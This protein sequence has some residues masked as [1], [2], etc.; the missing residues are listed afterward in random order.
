MVGESR[1]LKS[2]TD[3]A[4][5]FFKKLAVALRKNIKNDD[6]TSF[7]NFLDAY[8]TKYV[9]GVSPQPID[10]S[11]VLDVYL[12]LINVSYYMKTLVIPQSLVK[13]VYST[14][15]SGYVLR[16][17]PDS[18]VF[19]NDGDDDYLKY[20]ILTSSNWTLRTTSQNAGA[21]NTYY[22]DVPVQCHHNVPFVRAASG[23]TNID[24]TQD[25]FT[26]KSEM[27]KTCEKCQHPKRHSGKPVI[28]NELITVMGCFPVVSKYVTYECFL[29]DNQKFET[30]K[31]VPNR[32]SSARSNAASSTV[33]Y[34]DRVLSW[35]C[36]NRSLL[37]SHGTSNALIGKSHN[38]NPFYRV[39]ASSLDV[40]VSLKMLGVIYD[41][42]Q[43]APDESANGYS[44]KKEDIFRKMN[45]VDESFLREMFPPTSNDSL[46]MV[47]F[48]SSTYD[49]G[50]NLKK[51]A[52]IAIVQKHDATRV[53]CN[54]RLHWLFPNAHAFYEKI[55]RRFF[56]DSGSALDIVSLIREAV[57]GH[58]VSVWVK[59]KWLYRHFCEVFHVYLHIVSLWCNDS[60]CGSDTPHD[61]AKR[62]LKHMDFEKAKEIHRICTTVATPNPDALFCDPSFKREMSKE[63]LFCDGLNDGFRSYFGSGRSLFDEYSMQVKKYPTSFKFEPGE[64]AFFLENQRRFG[65]L[66][67]SAAIVERDAVGYKSFFTAKYATLEKHRF[68][69]ACFKDI[70]KEKQD[71]ETVVD[72]NVLTSLEN[73]L[74]A[75]TNETQK[76]IIRDM[77]HSERSFIVGFPGTGKTHCALANETIYRN[78]VLSESDNDGAVMIT[79]GPPSRTAARNAITLTLT[80]SMCG[81]LQARGFP[82]CKNICL[83]CFDVFKIPS[84]QKSSADR[85]EPRIPG[86]KCADLCISENLCLTDSGVYTIYID[87]FSNVSDQL[88]Y[89]F[90][91]ALKKLKVLIKRAFNREKILFRIIYMMDCLQIQPI[92]GDSL[93]KAIYHRGS[94]FD[95]QNDRRAK[96][97]II[98]P[99]IE[100]QRFSET[101]NIY[102][103]D[104]LII[105]DDA[106]LSTDLKRSAIRS[107]FKRASRVEQIGEYIDAGECY[108]F[109]DDGAGMKHQKILK[110]F[111]EKTF[112]FDCAKRNGHILALKK[113]HCAE[114]NETCKL[115]NVNRT[116]RN[117]RSNF[118]RN[119][120]VLVVENMY[121]AKR[122]VSELYSDKFSENDQFTAKIAALF[123]DLYN[124]KTYTFYGSVGFVKP[125]SNADIKRTILKIARSRKNQAS[126]SA[127][128]SHASPDYL[129]LVGECNN[130]IERSDEVAKT[131]R[132]AMYDFCWYDV[133]GPPPDIQRE[134][135]S[136]IF[137]KTFI[138]LAKDAKEKASDDISFQTVSRAYFSEIGIDKL[139]AKHEGLERYFFP[140]ILFENGNIACPVLISKRGNATAS[141]SLV[142]KKSEPS[143]DTKNMLSEMRARQFQVTTV[144]V[145]L[146]FGWC[147]T[148]D[149]Y[150]G[151]ESE[152]IMFFSKKK[153]DDDEPSSP[154]NGFVNKSRF[155]VSV[156][157]TKKSFAVL[158]DFDSFLD[159]CCS[160]LQDYDIE[161]SLFSRMIMREQIDVQN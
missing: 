9:D 71:R 124:G 35:E 16:F 116:L 22:D 64:S 1:I 135:E 66:V 5:S 55:N 59:N 123:G 46:N 159:G 143:N 43:K 153:D 114:I 42:A 108:H 144:D 21:L 28:S 106:A 10:K 32:A 44:K 107:L 150:Q 58:D 33:V 65:T 80:G 61:Y 130:L 3:V 82:N 6:E 88:Y 119:D 24:V 62:M 8:P 97:S 51:K 67:K 142:S 12:D 36:V 151:R 83:F 102:L 69:K 90:T 2:R 26:S 122:V 19:V 49:L 50:K 140:V 133:S 15:T 138:G 117:A 13:T 109:D 18:V 125:L 81:E 70:Y 57:F 39:D 115:L 113:T 149:G 27:K 94:V 87:E 136:F 158:G 47:V 48:S 105:A 104:V 99:L 31:C 139:H 137:N 98:Y 154:S 134:I 112:A 145:N 152:H 96:K 41:L 103:C 78:A 132:D 127:N 160:P 148:V 40:E 157:R 56:G 77:V 121:N 120:R 25:V 79:M 126:S 38:E 147:T 76:K 53:L 75:F 52:Q 63:F 72:D 131:I 100:P 141:K 45:N 29:N 4:S 95:T 101:S 146:R 86:T 89:V 110:A 54:D 156:T 111:F 93:C 34:S 129:K 91:L 128:V 11:E 85:S 37:Y 118:V 17:I 92:D 84:T 161:S 60:S 74:E 7:F 73:A 68:A 14:P 23:R 155:H 20:A 30:S